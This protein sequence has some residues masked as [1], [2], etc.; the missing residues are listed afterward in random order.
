MKFYEV[1]QGN[2]RVGFFKDKKLAR[3]YIKL[4]NTK[5]LIKS[6][7]IVQHEFLTEKDLEE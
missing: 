1:R 4:F 5:T 7:E 2:N 6:L 3:K